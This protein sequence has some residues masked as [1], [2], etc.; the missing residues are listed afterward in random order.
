MKKTFTIFRFAFLTISLLAFQACVDDIDDNLKRIDTKSFLKSDDELVKLLE[1]VVNEGEDPLTE[2]ICI[3]FVYPLTLL[4]YDQNF[5]VTGTQ[6]LTGDN[7]FSAFLGSLTDTQYISIS[8]P[9]STTLADGTIFSINNNQELKIAIES[10]SRED[11]LQ[12]CNNLFGNNPLCVWEVPYSEN[13]DNTYSSGIFTANGDGTIN[14]NFNDQNHTGT[15]TFLFV[16]NQLQ[17]NINLEGTSEVAQY[18]NFSKKIEISGETITIV[19]DSK[20][21]IL[22][23]KCE[24]TVSYL[25]GDEGPAGGIVFY[26]KGSYSTGWRYIEVSKTEL[27]VSEWG[28]SSSAIGNINPGIGKGFYNSVQ[29]A[30]FHDNLDSY[31]TDPAICDATNNGTVISKIAL[32]Y[33]QQDFKEWFLPSEQELHLIYENLYSQNLGNLIGT[34]YWSSTEIDV[35]TVKG[36]N[37]SSGEVIT[38]A[39]KPAF[40]ISARAIRYF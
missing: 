25:I 31:Y 19:N 33:S 20:N 3:D 2:I 21:I 34:T 14:F 35:A 1:Q 17:L 29:V 27:T 16:N 30:N 8:Y 24:V 26:D 5:H 11:I 39:K 15:W 36:I 38:L 32:L 28:C 4:V 23:K 6:T 22:Q 12:F 40:G 37:F 9:I 18:W 13:S 7:Q 10:C